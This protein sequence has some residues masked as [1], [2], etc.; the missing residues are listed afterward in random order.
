MLGPNIPGETP[1]SDISGLKITGVSTRRQLNVLEAENINQAVLRYFSSRPSRRKARFD[2]S[3]CLQLH[4]EMFGNV[5]NWAGEVRSINLNLGSP[6]FR[7]SEDLQQLLADL[8]SWPGFGMDL[9]EQSARLHHRAALIHPFQN[10]NGRWARMLANIWLRQH[11]LPVVI[12]PE[13]TI[14]AESPIRAEYLAA[15]RAA[16]NH[17]YAPLIELHRQYLQR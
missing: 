17:D 3:W 7:I 11:R 14:G 15:I 5:W 8:H 6:F 10:G 12:W 9:V 13:Q 4:H 1:L 16:D 2:F